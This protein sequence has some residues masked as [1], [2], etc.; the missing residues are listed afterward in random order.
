MGCR[1]WDAEA[2]RSKSSEPPGS[3]GYIK[4]IDAPRDRASAFFWELYPTLDNHRFPYTSLQG[5]SL[6]FQLPK[7]VWWVALS[8]A[9]NIL[10]S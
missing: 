1:R 7:L 10:V 6:L 3:D 9:I 8:D 2:V 4:G 5:R